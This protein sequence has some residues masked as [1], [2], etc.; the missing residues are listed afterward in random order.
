MVARFLAGWIRGI[1]Y[2]LNPDHRVK[3][4]QYLKEFNENT[5][6]GYEASAGSIEN[7][8]TLRPFFQLDEQLEIFDRSSGK[9]EVDTWYEAVSAFLVENS[10]ITENPAVETYITDKYLKM[11]AANETLKDF[12]ARSSAGYV[13]PEDME[14][15]N[16]VSSA[17]ISYSTVFSLILALNCFALFL[18]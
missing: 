1:G 12:A 2:M 13:W 11:V 9:S 8:F 14:S 10:V 18:G 17:L 16:E 4:E 15:G 3:S 7:D 6:P 5:L